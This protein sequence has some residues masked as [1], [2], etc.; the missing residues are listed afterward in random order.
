[1]DEFLDEFFVALVDWC[2][3]EAIITTFKVDDA[4]LNRA[5]S[6][7]QTLLGHSRDG[8]HFRDGRTGT[9][10]V[11]DRI[12]AGFKVRF[13]RVGDQHKGGRLGD[14]DEGVNG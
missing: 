11:V 10:V 7:I 13:L 4:L 9:T 6:V 8:V 3:P 14:C 2:G 1:M 5:P 12:G